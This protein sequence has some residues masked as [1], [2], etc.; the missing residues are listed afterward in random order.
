MFRKYLPF[1]YGTICIK[2]DG[3]IV[4]ILKR[5][6]NDLVGELIKDKDGKFTL[7][8]DDSKRDLIP[9]LNNL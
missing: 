7:K 3:R 4:R 8:L 5:D 6:L 9:H 1:T 2:K